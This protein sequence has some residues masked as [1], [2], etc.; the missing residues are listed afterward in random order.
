VED[1]EDNFELVRFWLERAAF[2]M[3]AGHDG[4]RALDLARLNCLT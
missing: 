2:V 4:Q 1:N 3:L